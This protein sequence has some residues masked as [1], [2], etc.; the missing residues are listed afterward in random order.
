LIFNGFGTS[1]SG[2]FQ[3]TDSEILWPVMFSFGAFYFPPGPVSKQ[4]EK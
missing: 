2:R 3:S 4:F 1:L